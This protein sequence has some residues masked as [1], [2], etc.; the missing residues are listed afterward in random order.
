[1]RS[2]RRSTTRRCGRASGGT[3]RSSRHLEFPYAWGGPIASTT[4]LTPFFGTL[5]GRLSYGLGYTGHGI[6][7]T[8]VAGRILAHLALERPSPLLELA[9]GAA[10]AVPVP[11]RAAAP[12]C[13]RGRHA[14]AAPSGR[15]ARPGLMLK[16]LDL[17]GIS[18]SS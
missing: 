15:G 4:R 9:D 5:G 16:A 3:S 18:F 11:A 13:G 7:S 8:R 2:L 1:M 12:P 6:G 17:F 14:L 10:Q